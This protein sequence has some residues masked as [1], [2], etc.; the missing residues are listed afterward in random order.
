MNDISTDSNGVEDLALVETKP[1]PK[2]SQLEAEPGVNISLAEPEPGVEFNDSKPKTMNPSASWE[3][4]LNIETRENIII[5]TDQIQLEG[6]REWTETSTFIQNSTES[7]TYIEDITADVTSSYDDIES[8][9]DMPGIET[10]TMLPKK[11]DTEDETETTIIPEDE[12]ETTIIPENESETT[13]IPEE[14]T[15]TTII[16]E[17]ESETTKIPEDETETTIIPEDETETTIIPEDETETTKIPEDESETTIIPEDETETTIIPEDETE[18]T[19]LPEDELETTI[20]P[21]DEIET[22][23]IPEDK[24]ETT[25]IPEDKT[26]TTIMPINEMEGRAMI[27]N[28]EDEFLMLS[29]NDVETS[30]NMPNIDYQTSTTDMIASDALNLKEIT[31][32]P[33]DD[34]S[35]VT[36]L[37]KDE[38]ETAG[39]PMEVIKMLPI[40]EKIMEV[41]ETTLNPMDKIETTFLSIDV[42]QTTI[43]PTEE[44][45]S[46]SIKIIEKKE[47]NLQIYNQEPRISL[48]DENPAVNKISEI[49]E[50][51]NLELS[52]GLAEETTTIAASAKINLEALETT[53]AAAEVD[54]EDLLLIEEEVSENLTTSDYLESAVAAVDIDSTTLPSILN[55]SGKFHKF[56]NY[57]QN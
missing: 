4:E 25:I 38:I 2:T 40:T 43:M 46:S 33:I 16:P 34:M 8:M 41:M 21:E 17:N 45:E 9:S 44:M 51:K 10:V 57:S 39:V 7:E 29:K 15:E 14:E 6:T 37:P 31:I 30:T 50:S 48:L 19:K 52:Q 27:K 3:P 23:K 36:P 28:I 1:G 55:K 54:S 49:F 35:T 22:T 20:I 47:E 56:E 5:N 12:T 42:S 53:S 24:T 18:T 13:I 26:E 11:E 32:S